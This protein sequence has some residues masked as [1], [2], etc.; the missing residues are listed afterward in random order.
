M[1]TIPFSLLDLAPVC[2]GSTP[3][4]ASVIRRYLGDPGLDAAGVEALRAIITEID[5]ARTTKLVLIG[6]DLDATLLES[7]LRTALSA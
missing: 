3:A 4:Q 5:E 7:T 1:T 2:E 6:Q